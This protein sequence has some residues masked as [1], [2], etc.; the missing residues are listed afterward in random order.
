MNIFKNKIFIIFL[1]LV[2]V[3]GLVVVIRFVNNQSQSDD[4]TKLELDNNLNK[5]DKTLINQPSTMDQSSSTP[6]TTSEVVKNFSHEVTL[7]TNLGVIKFKTYDADAPKTVNNYLTLAKKGFYD[8]LIFHRVIDGF[9]IQGGDPTGTGMGGPGYQFSDEL[10]PDTESYKAG[11][12]E[13]AVAM[14]N[15]G[16][17]TNGSQFFIMV[18]NV[19]LPHNYSIFGQVV[20][21][22]DIA[23]KIAKVKTGTGDKP[24]EPVIIKKVTVSE[25]K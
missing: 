21:G 7:E 14:A 6:V 19:P 10:N 8:T 2:V 25:I 9:M 24:L 17:D 20:E 18:A 22:L 23:K 5:I 3:I 11:Y 4:Q 15:S 13:G 16:P 1:V 12:V